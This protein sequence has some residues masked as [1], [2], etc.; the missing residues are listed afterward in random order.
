MA[1]LKRGDPIEESLDPEIEQQEDSIV[2]HAARTIQFYFMWRVRAM[3]R[4]ISASGMVPSSAVDD[5]K[6]LKTTFTRSLVDILSSGPTDDIRVPLAGSLIDLHVV[7]ASLVHSIKPT[8]G[9]AA[10]AQQNAE[11]GASQDREY[12]KLVDR[13]STLA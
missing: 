5:M 1:I 9:G 6:S 11:A 13:K 4:Q 2:L 7:F 12:L 8:R 10:G 3:Q